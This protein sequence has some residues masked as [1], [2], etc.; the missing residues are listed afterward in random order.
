MKKFLAGLVIVC[1]LVLTLSPVSSELS[2][3]KVKEPVQM[4]MDPGT[5]G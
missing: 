4:R 3:A 2:T 5:I 1:A